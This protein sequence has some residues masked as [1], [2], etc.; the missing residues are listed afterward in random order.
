MFLRAEIEFP[1]K[2]LAREHFRPDLC[3]Y[4]IH[5]LKW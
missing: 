4:R 2:E 3:T 5:I 1:T